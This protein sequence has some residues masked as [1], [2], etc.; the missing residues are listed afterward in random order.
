[1]RI[2]A[3]ITGA[4]DVRAIL[5]HIGERGIPSRMA[6][7]RGSPEWNKAPC[8]RVSCD[9][10]VVPASARKLVGNCCGVSGRPLAWTSSCSMGM[11]CSL[12]HW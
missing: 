8:V 3:F 4:V 1:M 9:A 5:E 10:Q 7:A 12:I 11:K 6:Q 2:I